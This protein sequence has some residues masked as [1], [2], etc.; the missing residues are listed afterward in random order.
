MGKTRLPCEVIR[1]AGTMILINP[2][3]KRFAITRFL[4]LNLTPGEKV[5]ECRVEPATST[6]V[7]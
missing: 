1:L 5:D 7:A 2:S 3:E 6:Y 4:F